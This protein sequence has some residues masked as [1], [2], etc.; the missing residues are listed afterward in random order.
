MGAV[1]ARLSDYVV[2]TSDNPRTEKPDA[3]IDE[4]MAGIGGRD[5][6]ER[7]ADREQAIAHAVARA[8]PGDIVL[9][10]GKGHENYQDFG[11]TVV[12]FDDRDIARKYLRA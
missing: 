1:A 2:I 5:Y 3:I 11:S 12:P 9:I 10:A 8:Q 4:I 6:V 7:I